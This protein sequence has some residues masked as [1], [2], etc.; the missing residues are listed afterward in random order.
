[1][2]TPTSIAA[3]L[4]TTFGHIR[5][6]RMADVPI[7]NE[8][9]GVEAVGFR[10]IDE[11]LLGVLVTPWFM[12]LMLL[13]VDAAAWEGQRAGEKTLHTLPA[14]CYE[15]IAGYEDGVGDY[16][17]CSLFSPMFE[18]AD[19]SA[20]VETA[21]AVMDGIMTRADAPTDTDDTDTDPEAASAPRRMSRRELFRQL[22][23]GG[24]A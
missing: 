19:H 1:V 15:F 20:A 17:M 9:I 22:A 2:R 21:T 10:E 11:G 3:Q 16:R 13:P 6:T 23:R 12:N 14:G 5:S 7:L 4:E 24:E 18:F 8:A